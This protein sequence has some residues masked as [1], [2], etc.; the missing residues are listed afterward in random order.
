MERL[1]CSYNRQDQPKKTLDIIAME[2]PLASIDGDLGYDVFAVQ[3]VH[4]DNIEKPRLESPDFLNE[5]RF[6]AF[7]YKN[8]LEKLGALYTKRFG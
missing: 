3:C 1:L 2:V 7:Y 8:A 6:K 4:I 5:D